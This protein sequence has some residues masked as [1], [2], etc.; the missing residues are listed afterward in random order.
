LI[1]TLVSKIFK[2]DLP[3]KK[4]IY[5]MATLLS[6]LFGVSRVSGCVHMDLL[7]LIAKRGLLLL[8]STI[9]CDDR[10]EHRAHS[11]LPYG[12]SN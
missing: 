2:I 3:K 4:V 6:L 8:T 12:T 5:K 11:G 7:H 9:T 10:N 1:P